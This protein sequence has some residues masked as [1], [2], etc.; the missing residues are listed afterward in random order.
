MSK[1]ILFTNS[2][3]TISHMSK[4]NGGNGDLYSFLFYIKVR[5]YTYKVYV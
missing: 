1:F 5:L 2:N 3:N 4:G